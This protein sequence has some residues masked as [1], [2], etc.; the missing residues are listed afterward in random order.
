MGRK[1]CPR[2]HSAVP[3]FVHGMNCVWAGLNPLD[4]VFDALVAVAVVPNRFVFIDAVMESLGV[5]WLGQV[6]LVVHFLNLCLQQLVLFAPV[7]RLSWVRDIRGLCCLPFR[8]KG[9]SC[10]EN[11]KSYPATPS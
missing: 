5:C 9:Q 1:G 7:F 6:G 8:L 3:R 2:Q 11:T 4:V 10:E